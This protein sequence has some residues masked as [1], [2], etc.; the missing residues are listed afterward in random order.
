[1]SFLP[2]FIIETNKL[3]EGS[4]YSLNPYCKK[5]FG[6]SCIN[7]YKKIE[8]PGIYVCPY[9]FNI[10]LT[11]FGKERGFIYNSILIN[12]E[13]SKK[14]VKMKTP[15]NIFQKSEFQ[16]L[17]ALFE[18]Q[19]KKIELNI[20]NEKNESTII[21]EIIHEIRKLSRDLNEQ[22]ANLA[23]LKNE[24]SA[25]NNLTDNILATIQLISIRIDSYEFQ[26][27]PETILSA[28]Q[29]IKI[30]KKFDK[31][32]FIL[33]QHAKKNRTNIIFHGESYT[34][35]DGYQIFELLPYILLDNAVK[36]SPKKQ[37]VE[38]TFNDYQK[39]V[40]VENIG[41]FVKKENIPQ[42]T[43]QGFRG[44][45]SRECEGSGIG[46]CLFKQIAD[47]HNIKYSIESNDKIL[48]CKNDIDYSTF[49]VIM[50]FE[51]CTN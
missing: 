51:N 50:N 29:R 7:F 6:S 17:V 39:E 3:S 10:C 18:Q 1:M 19:Q 35:I 43:N 9:G 2:T 34:R 40:I 44:V 36:Y 21:R 48:F 30:Y 14:K 23:K 16:Q 8:K 4:V 11:P 41:P 25:I 20:E 22:G 12:L 28:K 46:L 24:K 31:S 49:K 5:K 33:N 13:Y 32:R 38:V 42:L 37:N 15:K 27:N 47:L 45:N 26:K